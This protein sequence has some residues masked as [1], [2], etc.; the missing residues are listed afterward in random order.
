MLVCIARQ[1]RDDGDGL[2]H[3]ERLKWRDIVSGDEGWTAVID[4]ATALALGDD[5]FVRCSGCRSYLPLEIERRSGEL[6]HLH[7]TA[8]VCSEAPT[9]LLLALPVHN[10][11]HTSS[12]P[13]PLDVFGV[14]RRRARW[15]V[16]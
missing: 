13:I 8:H 3:V 2:Q 7:A 6:L 11:D 10:D 4:V 1:M 16:R 12:S 15:T 14:R 5:L 9:D